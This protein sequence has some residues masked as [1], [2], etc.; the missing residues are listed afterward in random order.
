[1]MFFWQ[2]DVA[3]CRDS[4]HVDVRCPVSGE[5]QSLSPQLNEMNRRPSQVD[6]VEECVPYPSARRSF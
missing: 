4:A 2:L 3:D 5:N 6:P 1:M